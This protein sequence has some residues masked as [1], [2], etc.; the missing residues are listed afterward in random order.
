MMIPS[1]HARVR[2]KQLPSANTTVGY[3]CDDCLAEYG[4]NNVEVK[5]TSYKNLRAVERI[6]RWD[7]TQQTFVTGLHLCRPH[8]IQRKWQTKQY[9]ENVTS[10]LEP[11]FRSDEYRQKFAKHGRYIRQKERAQTRLNQLIDR[12]KRDWTQGILDFADMS[13]SN[14]QLL[15]RRLLIDPSPQYIGGYRYRPGLEAWL[16]DVLGLSHIDVHRRLLDIWLEDQGACTVSRNYWVVVNGIV[17]GPYCRY[18]GYVI[19]R[20]TDEAIT[21]SSLLELSF[22]L[23]RILNHLENIKSVTNNPSFRV[24]YSYRGYLRGYYPDFLINGSEIIEIKDS[25]EL[26]TPLNQ[27][28][29]QALLSYSAEHGFVP[30]RITELDISDQARK[31][32]HALVVQQTSTT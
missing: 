18:H 19:N 8:S 5:E 23:D 20:L 4:W 25:R 29:W 30:K 9:R 17:R 3:I 24:E 13:Q 2:A 32:A 31:L 7:D 21:F 11:L 1:D 10:A 22:V 28:K 6:E 16:A 12:I 15:A 14:L 27:A 26:D